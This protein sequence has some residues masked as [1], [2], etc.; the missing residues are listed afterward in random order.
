MSFSVP[1]QCLYRPLVDAAWRA[2]CGRERVRPEDKVAKDAWYR[3][4]LRAALG[5]YT[6]KQ[7]NRARDFEVL[8]AHFEAIA[9]DSIEWQLRMY[10]GDAKRIQYELGQLCQR[11]DIDE[12]YLRSIARQALQVDALPELHLLSADLIYRVL[13]AAK[14]YVTRQLQ[15]GVESPRA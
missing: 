14:I 12:D 1:Q 7:C 2:H 5:I 15:R 13:V 8:M 3:E 9:G 4:Q 10:R 11:H 6:T